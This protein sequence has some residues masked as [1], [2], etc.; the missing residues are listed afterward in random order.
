[1]MSAENRSN[2]DAFFAPTSIA[3]IGASGDP[4][5]IGGLPINYLKGQK[6]GGAIY[7]VNPNR[8]EVQGLRAYASIADIPSGIDLAIVAVPAPDAVA[9]LRICDEKGV[10]AAIVFSAGFAEIGEQGQALQSELNDILRAGRLRVIGPNCGGCV[11][12]HNGAWST[13]VPLLRDIQSPPGNVALVTQSGAFANYG[14]AVGRRRGI[15]FSALMST[16][17][18]V[19]VD[20]ADGIEYMARN[21]ATDVILLYL[22]GT[23]DGPRLARA[24]RAAQELGKA[25]VAVKVGRTKAGAAAAA[26]HTAA[27]AGLDEVYDGI[28]RQFGVARARSIEELF[29]IG[30]ACSTGRWPG[31]RNVAVV[32]VSGGVGVLMADEAETRGLCVEPMPAAARAKIK[33][34]LPFAVPN[35]PVDVTA[36]TVNDLTIFEKALEVVLQDGGYGSVV[37][38]LG[39]MGRS[40]EFVARLLPLW[41]SFQRRFPE[42]VLPVISLFD[43]KTR[44]MLLDEPGM[45]VFEEPTHALRAVAA[46]CQIAEALE[47]ARAR[48]NRPEAKGS[49]WHPAQDGQLDEVDSLAI[50]AEAGLD[51]VP[52]KVVGDIEAAVAAA[53]EIGYP[54]V[55]KVVSP[56]IP[57]KAAVGG[58]VLGI[59]SSAEFR[60]A[61]ARVFA[62]FESLSGRP[63]LRGFIVAPMLSSKGE[64]IIGVNRDPVFGP[65]VMV[66]RGGT[67]VENLRQ[68]SFRL[69]PIDEAE[70]IEMLKES[71]VADPAR[72]ALSIAALNNIASAIR[73]FSEFVADNRDS[74]VSIDINPVVLRHDGRWV[75]VDALAVLGKQ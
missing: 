6:F 61:Y 65:V 1:M 20:I 43:D 51:V 66:G 67:A 68:V 23:R 47:R 15:R 64:I 10:K 14:F 27:L 33:D 73:R 11:N 2:L 34:I 3:V 35:N 21:A 12:F 46:M 17:N 57:H 69:A 72:A 75:A 62:R 70:A 5:R 54:V 31:S 39:F 60:K 53:D 19:D 32:S 55:L 40:P 13:F 30:Y 36:Q 16:G 38:Y 52:H 9:A 45:M 37:S 7:P 71:G 48:G 56:D 22:E 44:Q 28:F 8:T 4:N 63:R 29:D 24:L 58:V 59:D 18:E 41:Q 26:S 25:V 49:A 42:C 50:I 74:I